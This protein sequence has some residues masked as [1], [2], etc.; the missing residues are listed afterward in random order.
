MTRI[1]AALLPLLLVAG[2][3]QYVATS[4][5]VTRLEVDLTDVF[6]NALEKG[7]EVELRRGDGK[8]AASARGLVMERVAHG[9]YRLEARCP[10]FLLARQEIRLAL[11]EQTVRVRLHFGGALGG[12]QGCDGPYGGLVLRIKRGNAT[13][14][15]GQLWAKL[16]PLH[17]SGGMEARVSSSG[18]VSF[19]NDEMGP[20]ILLVSSGN[21]V[22]HQAVVDL[23]KATGEIQLP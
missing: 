9:V 7:C 6:G 14:G 19:V 17:G 16:V 2:E 11:R 3:C 10:G 8:A 22:W 12:G 18:W 13:A 4:A 1:V 15:A 5:D 20:Q 21:R 23:G